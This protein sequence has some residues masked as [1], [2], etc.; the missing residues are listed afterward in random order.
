[1]RKE[2]WF[3]AYTGWGGGAITQQYESKTEKT[4]KFPQ[5]HFI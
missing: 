3:V 5:D 1:V 2:I 4:K